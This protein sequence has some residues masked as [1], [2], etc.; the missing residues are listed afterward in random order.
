MTCLKLIST[1]GNDWCS[2]LVVQVPNDFLCADLDLLKLKVPPA[3]VQSVVL[4]I[5]CW[6]NVSG[7]LS[8]RCHQLSACALNRVFVSHEVTDKALVEARHCGGAK[9]DE[10]VVVLQNAVPA[11]GGEEYV[12]RL[13]QILFP[14]INIASGVDI[15]HLIIEDSFAVVV[16][17]TSECL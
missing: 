8:H 16:P 13:L 3:Y 14:M 12:S 10:G 11:V 7:F 9:E 1:W 2:V 4:A 15:T 5:A 17:L 6:D